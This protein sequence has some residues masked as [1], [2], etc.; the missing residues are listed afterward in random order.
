METV[1]GFLKDAEPELKGFLC[2]VG[3]FP[4]LF[5]L[6]G[7]LFPLLSGGGGISLFVMFFAPAM[8]LFAMSIWLSKRLT[9]KTCVIFGSLGFVITLLGGS[10]GI[11]FILR[12]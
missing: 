8:I 1:N 12:P 5:G 4:I 9:L 3:G 11:Y 6:A 2:V 7:A 10:V